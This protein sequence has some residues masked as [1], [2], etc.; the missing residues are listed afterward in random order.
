MH[1]YCLLLQACPAAWMPYEDYCYWRARSDIT[2]SLNETASMC[3]GM[4]WNGTGQV[5]LPSD[6]PELLALAGLFDE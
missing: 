4:S 1:C 3:A 2:L 6:V 5:P